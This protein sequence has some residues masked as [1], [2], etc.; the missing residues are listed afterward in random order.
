MNANSTVLPW[1]KTYAATDLASSRFFGLSA[2]ERG[3]LDSMARAYWLDGELPQD[4]RLIA[5]VVRMAEQEVL[6]ALTQGVLGHFEADEARPGVL[7]HAGLRT[8]R[9]AV[10]E[11]RRRMSIGGQ[12]GAAITNN[13]VAARSGYPAKMVA[14]EDR[15]PSSTSYSQSTSNS[16]SSGTGDCAEEP[17]ASQAGSPMSEGLRQ[18]HDEYAEVERKTDAPGI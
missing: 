11:G 3:L 14:G 6:S 9:E 1:Y 18:W 8:Q 7:H 15:G 12:R 4:P 16:S 13:R 5:R 2:A 10:K 17:L